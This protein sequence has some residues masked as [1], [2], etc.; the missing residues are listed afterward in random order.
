MSM[1]DEQAYPWRDSLTDKARC[2]CCQH[3]HETP[4]NDEELA[5]AELQGQCGYTCG[6]SKGHE[7]FY[8]LF[9]QKHDCTDFV[10]KPAALVFPT[11]F[12]QCEFAECATCG[13]NLNSVCDGK[14][15]IPVRIKDG[16]CEFWNDANL[17]CRYAIMVAAI[18][19]RIKVG[20]YMNNKP[21][22]P[23]LCDTCKLREWCFQYPKKC[24]ECEN[25][26]KDNVVEQLD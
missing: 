11:P 23:V 8:P 19:A 4:P 10:F 25:Y 21:T 6:C 3:Y 22:S 1:T 18:C 16:K 14:Q 24:I 2:A 13:H 12:N 9:A 20:C 26:R 7:L 5:E 17:T 15:W